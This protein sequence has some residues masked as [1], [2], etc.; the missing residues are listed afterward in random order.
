MEAVAKLSSSL[1]DYLE[2][3]YHLECRDNSARASDIA[4]SL[5]VSG[6][7]VTGALHALSSK[8]MINYKP[9]QDITLTAEGR[10]L[11]GEVVS[12]HQTLHR[13]FVDVL[14]VEEELAQRAACRMEHSLPR[15]ILERLQNFVEY[16]DASGKRGDELI[17]KF[18]SS[19]AK[20]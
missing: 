3:I 4:R 14:D 13:F 12:R 20:G 2:A 8:K 11:A 7:S 19:I 15:T 18:K 10:R 9:Y 16:I 17:E 5:D 6:A 1:E